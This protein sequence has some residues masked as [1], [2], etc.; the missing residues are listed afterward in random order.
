MLH[1][2]IPATV[3]QA[4][5]AHDSDYVQRVAQGELTPREVRAI[6]LPQNPTVRERS[7]ASAG[8]AGLIGARIDQRQRCVHRRAQTDRNRRQSG[9]KSI[10]RELHHLDKTLLPGFGR[11]LLVGDQAV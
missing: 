9:G 11:E 5:L 10:E 4:S 3:Q 6:G 8:D 7:F 1:Q 2:A